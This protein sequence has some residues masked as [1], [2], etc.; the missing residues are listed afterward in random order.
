MKLALISDIHGNALALEAVLADAQS[1]G[2]HGYV[3][4]GDY[5]AIGPDP[6][7]VTDRIR[8]LSNAAFVRGN[9]DH[10]IVHGVASLVSAAGPLSDVKLRNAIAE[11]EGF[12][13]TRGALACAGHL[14]WY[15]GLP[16]EHRFTLPSGAL[17]LAVHA[18]PGQYEGSGFHPRQTEDVQRALLHNCGADL[19]ITGHTH[20]QLNIR[21]GGVQLVNPGSV[22]NPPVPDPQRPDLRASYALLAADE[23]GFTV[24]HRRAD[25][26]H[27]AVISLASERG[28]PQLGHIAGYMRGQVAPNWK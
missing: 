22:S 2:A 26:D 27:E 14:G 13:W 7:A 18:S 24:E 5:A 3:F 19:V 9:T 23:R 10:Y 6:V 8:A 15:A 12:A 4:V 21:V 20:V 16:I 17:A 25:Y 11:A 28:H 1:A